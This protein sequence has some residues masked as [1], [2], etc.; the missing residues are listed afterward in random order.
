MR[1]KLFF[2]EIIDT[3][4]IIKTGEKWC[5]ICQKDE[6][7]HE[8]DKLMKVKITKIGEEPRLVII[9]PKCLSIFSSLS[10]LVIE[11]EEKIEKDNKPQRIRSKEKASG[12]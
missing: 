3:N 4:P 8:L 11:R 12:K 2:I 7:S 9:C 5:D 1:E 6:G 10:P